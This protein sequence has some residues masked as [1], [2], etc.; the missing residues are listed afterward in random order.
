MTNMSMMT[1][2]GHNNTNN[3]GENSSIHS[4]STMNMSDGD[5]NMS[6]EDMSNLRI[7]NKYDRFSNCTSLSFKSRKAFRQPDN[8]LFIIRRF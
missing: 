7:S 1:M 4:I 6:L 5:D 3:S 2:D 8:E